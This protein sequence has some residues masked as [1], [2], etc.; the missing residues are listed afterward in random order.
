MRRC[1]KKVW[2]MFLMLQAYLFKNECAFLKIIEN[3]A[4]DYLEVCEYLGVKNT[5][6]VQ[7]LL[8]HIKAYIEIPLILR[9]TIFQDIPANFKINFRKNKK[10]TFKGNV[11]T[12]NRYLEYVTEI[13]KQRAVERTCI[14]DCM[15]N[16]P[17]ASVF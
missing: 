8:F 5:E 16:V 2:R 3:E 11:G 4:I 12:L 15:K 14:L 6:E 1:I 7:D 9:T 17:F 10:S 13:E